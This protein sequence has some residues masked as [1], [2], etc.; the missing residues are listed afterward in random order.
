MA[1][2]DISTENA[3]RQSQVVVLGVPVKDYK[4]NPSCIQPGSLVINVASYKNVDPEALA[5]IE[6]VKFISAVGKITVAMLERNL[7]RLFENFHRGIVEAD[8]PAVRESGDG[9][10]ASGPAKAVQ[11]SGDLSQVVV[12][13]ALVSAVCSVLSLAVAFQRR[14]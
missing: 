5:K 10:Q 14:Q 9:D 11:Q 2:C 3:C 8:Y 1:K 4:I 7:L 6:N 13:A 12:G